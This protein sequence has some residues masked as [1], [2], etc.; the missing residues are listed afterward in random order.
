[1]FKTLLGLDEEF[2][3]N[4]FL[5]EPLECQCDAKVQEIRKNLVNRFCE[6]FVDYYSVEEFEGAG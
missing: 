5:R 3:L 2:I 6:I 1:M 4:I